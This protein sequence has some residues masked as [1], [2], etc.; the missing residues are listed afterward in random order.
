VR[1]N[2]GK[3]TN[4]TKLGSTKTFC[5]YVSKGAATISSGDPSQ[6]KYVGR[7]RETGQRNSGSFPVRWQEEARRGKKKDWTMGSGG[8]GNRGGHKME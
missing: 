5:R 7:G 2:G 4:R 8:E 1:M 6:G 3:K